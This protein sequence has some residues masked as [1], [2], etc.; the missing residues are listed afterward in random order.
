MVP[1]SI[2]AAAVPAATVNEDGLRVALRH[3][4]TI[5]SSFKAEDKESLAGSTA[6]E[7]MEALVGA[8]SAGHD[9]LDD[10]LDNLPFKAAAAADHLEEFAVA[11]G[12]Q[13]QDLLDR[14]TSALESRPGNA[15]DAV[16][17]GMFEAMVDTPT[18]ASMQSLA[19]IAA[20][21]DAP[22]QRALGD[23]DY[24]IEAFLRTQMDD[25]SSDGDGDGDGDDSN[26]D[27][28][29]IG[30]IQVELES[31]KSADQQ[32]LANHHEVV[33]RVAWRK[34]AAALYARAAAL[35]VEAQMAK[36]HARFLRSAA[37]S[38]TS[39]KR[40]AI[41]DLANLVRGGPSV[42]EVAHAVSVETLVRAYG[43]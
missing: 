12:E 37:I 22:F 18:V 14:K 43:S 25:A 17:A 42:R 19:S 26:D 24:E 1:D 36:T 35:E 30:D 21:I 29:C 38:A 6:W 7:G 33:E 10:A 39:A 27:D 4:H 9:V 16:V 20:G 40:D 34:E 5:V 13:T 3:A 11:V 8:I 23:K 32:H 31:G 41:V 28:E 15:R 2:P